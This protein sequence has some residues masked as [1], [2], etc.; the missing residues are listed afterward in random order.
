VIY[1]GEEHRNNWHI[2][3]A[4]KILNAL[5]ENHRHPLLAM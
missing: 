5:I 4:L 3:A 1:L 2:E